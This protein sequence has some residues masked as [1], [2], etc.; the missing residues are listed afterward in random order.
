MFVQR[1]KVQLTETIDLASPFWKNIKA[2]LGTFDRKAPKDLILFRKQLAQVAIGRLP[3]SWS[4]FVP[5]EIV[6]KPQV[7][8]QNA[9]ME[10]KTA[11]R[12]IR[13]NFEKSSRTS[14]IVHDESLIGRFQEFLIS[15][16]NLAHRARDSYQISG[17]D[18][19][20]RARILDKPW[21]R[22]FQDFNEQLKSED[23]KPI[24]KS[25]LRKIRKNNC[26]QFR[27]AA[28]HDI[29]Y[30]MCSSCSKL[31]MML[32]SAK[33]NRYLREW[34]IN[35]D[36]LLAESV[37]DSGNENCL[38]NTCP[39]CTHDW[40]VPKVRDLIPNFDSIKHQMINYPELVKYKKNQSYTHK[41]INQVSTIDEFS[42]ELTGALFCSKTKATGPKVIVPSNHKLYIHLS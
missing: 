41:W 4:Q 31:D 10:R 21:D 27:Q 20:V 13:A 24:S 19:Q 40:I 18:E 14:T 42:H 6:E 7:A 1:N 34:Q 17:S 12:T 30:A 37:C 25:C 8:L 9:G 26:K 3:E 23:R 11:Y 39:N 38:W 32:A 29:E 36:A 22:L 2:L 15:N 5:T 33:K 16:S 35:K 28:K